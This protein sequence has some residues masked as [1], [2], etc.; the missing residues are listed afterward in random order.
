MARADGAAPDWSTLMV[1]GPVE[2]P[3][4]RGRAWFEWTATVEADAS[5]GSP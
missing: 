1:K 4:L 3:D 5:H 2:V